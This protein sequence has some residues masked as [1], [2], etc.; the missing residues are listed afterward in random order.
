MPLS[1]DGG[2]DS[3]ARWVFSRR[4]MGLIINPARRGAFQST[5][6]YLDVQIKRCCVFFCCFFLP[7]GGCSL[8]LGGRGRTLNGRYV[9]AIH[10]ARAVRDPRVEEEEEEGARTGPRQKPEPLQGQEDGSVIK[11]NG[12]IS[13]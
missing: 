10:V 8:C 12:L 4:V 11:N 13:R 5:P 1:V 7:T 3:T 2:A 9:I 6:F